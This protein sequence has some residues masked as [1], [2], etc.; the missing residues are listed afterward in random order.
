[1]P[2]HAEPEAILDGGFGRMDDRLEQP[3][4]GLSRD[5]AHELRDLP[6]GR[7][8]PGGASPGQ[9]HAL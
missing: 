5:Y 4:L 8:E 3:R 1:M 9:R 2:H 7:R 6:C